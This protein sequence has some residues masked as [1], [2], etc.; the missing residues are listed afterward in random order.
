MSSEKENAIAEHLLSL[1]D[2]KN[3]WELEILASILNIDSKALF[4]FIRT[5]PMAFGLAVSGK[6]LFITPELTRDVNS[7][8]REQFVSW[9]Q[10][11]AQVLL[12]S[13][14]RHRRHHR[15]YLQDRLFQQETAW[16][17][18]PVSCLHD[19]W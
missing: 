9:Y 19:R 3:V 2:K 15:L 1:I 17:S 16:F 18:F 11:Y 6:K 13:S 10:R 7:E 5:L 8:I 12:R 14:Q 4:D